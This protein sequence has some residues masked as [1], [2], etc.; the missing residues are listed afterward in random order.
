M[1]TCESSIKQNIQKKLLGG[2]GGRRKKKKKG[3]YK[4]KGTKSRQMKSPPKK[5][6]Y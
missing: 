2:G 4:I 3:R 6:D 5:V 1:K